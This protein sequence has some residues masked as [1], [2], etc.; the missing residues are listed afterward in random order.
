MEKEAHHKESY[1]NFFYIDDGKHESR[2]CT[3]G[4]YIC[5]EAIT[6]IQHVLT[7]TGQRGV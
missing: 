1:V 7:A 6:A 4:P 2:C 3:K 5:I